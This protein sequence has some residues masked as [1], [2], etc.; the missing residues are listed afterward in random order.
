MSGGERERERERE[1]ETGIRDLGAVVIGDA[2][3]AGLQGLV[4]VVQGAGP[5]ALLAPCPPPNPRRVGS[6]P[7]ELER[8]MAGHNKLDQP[9]PPNPPQSSP[10]QTVE[11]GRKAFRDEQPAAV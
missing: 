11:V 5:G 9:P 1:R 2:V 6:S 10:W 7:G 4:Q 8:R 3:G